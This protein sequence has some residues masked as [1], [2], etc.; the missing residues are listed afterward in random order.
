MCEGDKERWSWRGCVGQRM[1]L[2]VSEKERDEAEEAVLAKEWRYVWV[3]KREIKLKRFCWKR[4][5][6][7]V[8][9]EGWEENNERVFCFWFI[10]WSC[11]IMSEWHVCVFTTCRKKILNGCCSEILVYSKTF[12]LLVLNCI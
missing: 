8:G 11:K 4:M 5:M 7:C 2:C 10:F 1:L 6:L 9:D 12:Y 3:R